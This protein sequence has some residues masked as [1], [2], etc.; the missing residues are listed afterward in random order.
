MTLGSAWKQPFQKQEI[1]QDI[2]LP[3]YQLHRDQITFADVRV[4]GITAQLLKEKRSIV[5]SLWPEFHDSNSK[6]LLIILFIT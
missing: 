2:I 1:Q 5:E 4:N 6:I 3:G